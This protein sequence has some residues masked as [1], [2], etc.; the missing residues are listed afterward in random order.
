MELE[1]GAKLNDNF[2]LTLNL[3]DIRITDAIIY[4]YVD[5]DSYENAGNVGTQG[6]ELSAKYK[7]G[8]ID[9]ELTYSFYRVNNDELPDYNVPD[10]KYVNLGFPQHK[11]T[12]YASIETSEKYQCYITPSIVYYSKKYAI[13]SSDGAW[14][15]YYGTLD[16]AM[17]VN[18]SLLCK[19]AFKMEGLGLSL[20]VYNMFDDDFYYVEPYIGYEGYTPGPSREVV[21]KI[22]KKF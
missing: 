11:V 3:F 2:L 14:N 15:L 5:T 10:E 16:S 21:L 6:L 22:S 8:R 7:S 20:S 4:S 18:L 19:D 17:L 13:T 12:F 1:G 9:S